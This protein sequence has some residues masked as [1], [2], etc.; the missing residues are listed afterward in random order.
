M[1][2]DS[3]CKIFVKKKHVHARSVFGKLW[4][5]KEIRILGEDA[6]EVTAE[7]HK[8][9]EDAH[10]HKIIHL[11]D[12]LKRLKWHKWRH[13][14][15]DIVWHEGERRGVVLLHDDWEEEWDIGYTEEKLQRKD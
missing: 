9:D 8:E 5:I 10:A 6:L 3:N 4:E 12:R 13:E 2:R 15:K 14:R 1:D 7:S 11:K